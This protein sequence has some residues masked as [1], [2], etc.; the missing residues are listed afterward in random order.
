MSSRRVYVLA[1]SALVVVGLTDTASAANQRRQQQ[2]DPLRPVQT[3]AN[4][5]GAGQ[6]VART[7]SALT[8]TASLVDEVTG[9]RVR[10]QAR[11]RQDRTRAVAQQ[12]QRMNNILRDRVDSLRKLESY[13]RMQGSSR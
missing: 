1:L 4:M 9:G 6:T 12:R 2:R 7:R 13:R 8:A 11:V 5:L 10:A 3:V